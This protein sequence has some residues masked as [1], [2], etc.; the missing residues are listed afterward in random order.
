M[1]WPG[2]LFKI[3]LFSGLWKSR[4]CLL[5][6]LWEGVVQEKKMKDKRSSKPDKNIRNEMRELCL[7]KQILNILLF[8]LVLATFQKLFYWHG[9]T[10]CISALSGIQRFFN[11]CLS[12]VTIHFK[13]ELFKNN[14]Q[15]MLFQVHEWRMWSVHLWGGGNCPA[16]HL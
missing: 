2:S 4:F 8:L 13:T 10:C 16:T 6:Y 3:N 15:E 12:W 11:R 1:W 7:L 14:L 5:F 9:E